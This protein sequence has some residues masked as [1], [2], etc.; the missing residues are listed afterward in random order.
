VRVPQPGEA[1]GR[2]QAYVART[3]M[4]WSYKFPG[5]VLLAVVI[6]AALGKAVP[7]GFFWD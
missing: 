1:A 5:V 6:A 4:R 7:L 2:D 3:M